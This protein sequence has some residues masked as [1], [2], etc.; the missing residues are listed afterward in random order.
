MSGLSPD[1]FLCGQSSTKTLRSLCRDQ[2][3]LFLL[4]WLRCTDRVREALDDRMRSRS[5]CRL[6]RYLDLAAGERD[7]LR[8]RDY[9]RSRPNPR[10]SRLLE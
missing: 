3:G 4:E 10:W 7:W 2:A 6:G 9:F 5:R 1:S 8:R